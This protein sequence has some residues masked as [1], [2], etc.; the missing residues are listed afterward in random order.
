MEDVSVTY[1]DVKALNELTWQV[2]PGENWLISGPNG[3]G[4]STL[5]SL[6]SADNPQGYN[7]DFHLFGRKRGSGE[8]IWDIKKKIGIV[9]SALQLSYKV[10]LKALEVV[11]SGFLIL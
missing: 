9:T 4:K 11:L 6:V 7:Q 8:T 2:M 10:P 1:G 3:A 5:L